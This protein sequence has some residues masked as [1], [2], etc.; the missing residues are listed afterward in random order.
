MRIYGGKKEKRGEMCGVTIIRF[1]G[2]E[3][4]G[5][6]AI[7]ENADDNSEHTHQSM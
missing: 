1:D 2:I 3:W 6:G 4:V 5:C 7:A